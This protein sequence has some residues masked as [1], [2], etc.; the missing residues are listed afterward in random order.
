MPPG[1][2]EPRRDGSFGAI[3]LRYFGAVYESEDEEDEVGSK[4]K[5][6]AGPE[7][8][9]T[10]SPTRAPSSEAG[11]VGV[12]GNSRKRRASVD[13]GGGTS[14]SSAR[15]R[16]QAQL[17]SP[18]IAEARGRPVDRSPKSVASAPAE[19]GLGIDISNRQ[20][21]AD[22]Y[23][24]GSTH[25]LLQGVEHQLNHLKEQFVRKNEQALQAL[26]SAYSER[27]GEV[28]LLLRQRNTVLG[29]AVAGELNRRLELLHVFNARRLDHLVSFADDVSR[30]GAATA[31][32]TI[33][34]DRLVEDLQAYVSQVLDIDGSEGE[35]PENSTLPENTQAE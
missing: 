19:L 25:E 14:G 26:Q 35:D 6:D 16:R 9:L 33:E 11:M 1:A 4:G 29:Q 17:L 23:R 20:S 31:R 5:D 7:D 10:R 3:P 8:E 28:T 34:R 15:R 12:S 13:R 27:I 2:Q 32:R 18:G 24:S 22:K 21:R 30:L